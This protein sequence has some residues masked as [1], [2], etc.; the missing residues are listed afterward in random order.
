M[1]IFYASSV[2]ILLRAE[3]NGQRLVLRL[4]AGR[5][6]I[7]LTHVLNAIISVIESDFHLEF[8]Q[9]Y[10]TKVGLLGQ[11]VDNFC[12]SHD[13]IMQEFCRG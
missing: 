11:E 13:Y 3:V 7:R 5:V 12:S 10:V 8:I 9:A 4:V 6:N 2:L 1:I